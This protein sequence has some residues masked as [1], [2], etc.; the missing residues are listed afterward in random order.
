MKKRKELCYVVMI[1]FEVVATMDNEVKTREK[2]ERKVN[3]SRLSGLR[4]GV[5]FFAV[6]AL[7]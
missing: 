3:H 1:C 6:F 7:V 5:F 2:L 4:S